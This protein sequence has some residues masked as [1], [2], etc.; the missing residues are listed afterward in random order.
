MKQLRKNIPP[1]VLTCLLLFTFLH[2]KAQ[3]HWLAVSDFGNAPTDARKGATSFR[4]NNSIYVYGGWDASGIYLTDLWKYSQSSDSWTLENATC[5]ITGGRAFAASFSIGNKAYIVGGKNLSGRHRDVWEFNSV[6]GN[7]TLLPDSLPGEI[8]EGHSAFTIGQKAYVGLGFNGATYNSD[9]YAF[10]Q[11]TLS[12]TQIPDFPGNARVYASSFTLGTKGYCGIGYSGAYENDFYCYDPVANS[13]TQIADFGGTARGAAVSF[14]ALGMGYVGMGDDGTDLKSDF[15]WYDAAA[16]AWSQTAAIEA[17]GRENGIG[18]SLSDIGYAGTGSDN[19]TNFY[20]EMW[21]W[22]NDYC[23]LELSASLSQI[24]CNADNNGAIDLTISGGAPA[25]DVL[26][27][28]GSTSEDIAN[29]SPGEYSVSITDDEGCSLNKS[30]RISEP[31]ELGFG[32]DSTVWNYAFNDGGDGID[33]SEKMCTDDAGNIYITG[34]F[35][36]DVTFGSTSMTSFGGSDIFLAK[37]NELGNLSWVISAGGTLNDV[38]NDI[39][40]DSLG[41]IYITGTFKELAFFGATQVQSSGSGAT[42]QDQE[43]FVAKYSTDGDLVWVRTAGG[44]F[45]DRGLGIYTEANGDCYVTGSFQGNATFQSHSLLSAGGDD[46]YTAKINSYGVF[47]WVNG[48]GGTSEDFGFEITKD[49]S[50]KVI[51]AGTFQNTAAFGG[52]NL[53]SLGDDDIF[54]LC[55]D[56][57]GAQQWVQQAGGPQN[58]SVSDITHDYNGFI[59]LTGSFKATASFGVN[60]LTSAGLTDI[61]IAKYSNTGSHQ[62]SYRAGGS[63]ADYGKGLNVDYRNKIYMSGAFSGTAQIDTM[64]LTS[65]GGLDI[66][67]AG[68]TAAGNFFDG[69]HVGSPTDEIANTIVQDTNDNIIISGYITGNITF[70]EHALTNLGNK[71][72]FVARADKTF[73]PRAAVVVQ[74]SC[75]E[76]GDGSIEIEVGGGTPPYTFAWSNGENTQN[77]YNLNAGSYYL[78]VTDGANCTKDTTIVLSNVNPA[79]EPPLV[80]TVD[81]TLFC[82][83]DPGDITLNAEGGSGTTLTWLKNACLESDGGQIVGTGTP[84]TIESPEDITT[85]YAR[86]ETVC[87]TSACVSI[88][89]VVLGQPT[90]PEDVAAYPDEFCELNVNFVTLS[91]DNTGHTGELLSWYENRDCIG[92]PIATGTPVDITSPSVTTWYYV[93]WETDGCGN[94]AVDSVRVIVLDGPIAVDTTY[95]DTT[96]ICLGYPNTISLSADGG[97]GD[98]LIWTIN[99]C[100]GTAVGSGTPLNIDPPTDTT[101]Y[102]VHWENYCGESECDSITINVLQTPTAPTGV[103]ADFEEFCIGE[104]DSITL[105][106]TEAYGGD[107]VWYKGYCGLDSITTGDVVKVKAPTSIT[108]YY[109]RVENLCGASPYPCPYVIITPHQPPVANFT[110]LGDALCLNADPALLNGTPTGTGGVYSTTAAAGLTDNG[111]GTASFDPALAG[112]GLWDIT[113]TYTDANGCMDDTTY[114]VAVNPLPVVNYTGLNLPGYCINHDNQPI[115]LTGNPASSSGFFYGEAI[116]DYGNGTAGFSPADGTPGG[117]YEIIYRYTDGNGCT[118]SIIKEVNIYGL[119]PALNF[120]LTEPGYCLDA[121]PIEL[122]GNQSGNPSNAGYFLGNGIQNTQPGKAF[123]VPPLAGAGVHDISYIYTNANGCTY[124]TTRTIEVYALPVAYFTGLLEN[125]CYEGNPSMLIG[126]PTDSNGV[127]SYDGPT[128]GLHDNLNGTAVFY[129]DSATAGIWNINYYYLDTVTGC[130]NDSSIAVNVYNRI[131]V[132]IDGLEDHYCVDAPDDTLVGSLAPQGTF[133]PAVDYLFDM[134]DGRVIF[135]PSIAGVGT[136]PI[137]YSWVDGNGCEGDTTILATVV[138]LPT[139]TVTSLDSNYCL[140]A[141]PDTIFGNHQPEGTFSILPG[142]GLADLGNGKAI[143]TASDAG[144]GYHYITYSFTDPNGCTKDSTFRVNVWDLPDITITGFDTSYYCYDEDTINLNGSPF[145]DLSAGFSGNGILDNDPTTG[146]ARWAA[147]LA[148]DLAGSG[149]HTISYGLSDANGCVSDTSWQIFVNA[150]PIV[151][152]SGLP[153]TL[154][155]N[156]DAITLTANPPNN[157]GTFSGNGISDLMNGTAIFDPSDPSV[158]AGT[159]V[160]ITYAFTDYNNCYNDT[161]DSVYIHPLPVKPEMII[162]DTNDYCAGIVTDLTL[163]IE[164]GWGD[165]IQW[166]MKSCG[167]SLIATTADTFL[168]ITAPT[169]TTWFWARWANQCAISECDSLQILVKLQPTIMDSIRVDTNDICAGTVDSLTLTAFGGNGDELR[170]YTDSCGGNY[171]GSGSEIRIETPADTTSFFAR[172]ESMC[173]TSDCQSLTVNIFPQPIIPDQLAVDVNNFCSGEIDSISL[174]AYGGYGTVLEWFSP[175]CGDT[176]V[177]EGDS[178]RIPAPLDTAVYFARWRNACDTT[179]CLSIQVD[180]RPLPIKPDTLMVDNNDYC[181]LSVE[182]IQLSAEGGFGD[183]VEWR[184]D[185]CNGP[186]VAQGNP[187]QP[188]PAPV[189]TTVYYASYVNNCGYSDCDSIIINVR[190][191]SIR[192]DTIMVDTNFFCPAYAGLVNLSV[193]GGLG[194]T[195]LWHRDSCNGTLLG[196]TYNNINT[197]AFQAPD[198]TTSYFVSYV[199]SCDTSDC[200]SMEVIVN[201]PLPVDTITADTTIICANSIPGNIT[202][203]AEGGRG[204]SIHWTKGSCDGEELGI[205]NPFNILPPDTTTVYFAKWVN[206]CGESECN[207]IRIIVIPDPIA[208]DTLISNHNNFCPNTL[209]SIKFT[210]VGG[211][212]DTV[213]GLPETVRWFANSCGGTEL[214]TGVEFWLVPPPIVTTQYYARWE[215][216]CGVSIC[217]TLEVLVN[218]PEPVDSVLLDTNYFCPGDVTS[219]Q[220]T[221]YGGYGDE[222]MWYKDECLTTLVVSTQNPIIVPAPDTTTTYWVTWRNQCDTAECFPVTI[223][224]NIPLTPDTIIID[225]NNYCSDYTENIQLEVLGGRG[226]TVRWFTNSC[227]GPELGLGNPLII[228]PFEDTTMVYARWENYCGVSECIELEVAVVPHPELDAGPAQDSICEEYTYTFADAWVEFADSILWTVPEGYGSFSD[229]KDINTEYIPNPDDIEEQVNVWIKLYAFGISPCGIYED[230]IRISINPTPILSISPPNPML[231]RDSSIFITAEGA[232]EYLWTPNIGLDTNRNQSVTI[233]L[234]EDQTYRMYGTSSSGC[235]DSLDFTIPVL[236]PPY[237]NLGDNLYLFTC[238]PVLLDA[239]KSDGNINYRWQDG[240]RNRTYEV[241]ED[242]EYYVS[243]W[244]EACSTSDTIFIQLCQGYMYMPN[245]FTPNKDGINEV[246]AP[247]TSDP[248]V[249]FEMR[250]Y[251]RSGRLVFTTE[252]VLEGWDGTDF[253]GTEC[254]QGIYVWQITYQGEGEIS[255]GVKRTETGRLTLLR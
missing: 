137:T 122:T 101:T 33:Q 180:V 95:A 193:E 246:F 157:L 175:T 203:Y 207:S 69:I 159:F 215:N 73:F 74:P 237:V 25:Y 72:V 47:E 113:F 116:T 170:W 88:E 185:S 13:W 6:N 129:P 77:I 92:D 145:S 244:N 178:I 133:G 40:I 124:D 173:D 205:G 78:L 142:A 248:D 3:D 96:E 192:P 61:Y 42:N 191:L 82:W 32:L 19:G 217:D 21:K 226:D 39:G 111:D 235:V 53:T 138:P 52:T 24:S 51:S 165:S 45:D 89:V 247:V 109:A 223:T 43:I 57:Y 240:S 46:I 97:Y 104:I 132:S 243:V 182:L 254:P 169:D 250:I 58:E 18:F 23:T 67:V 221:A 188:I 86:W 194:D 108:T 241:E 148:Y 27:N 206:Y 131:A 230:S 76:A 162:P 167:D 225:T 64:N 176:L 60:T 222:L 252:D 202:F 210:A 135:K 212:G 140:N 99:A 219:V 2:P 91:A 56:Q 198:T 151:S 164:G 184:I 49:V 227:E 201:E 48:A 171:I 144:P 134:S 4:I 29:L 1:L 146:T 190:P 31:M 160:H 213:S 155:V 229:P 208:P 150:L 103:L 236:P 84:L 161:I 66:L 20:R 36:S 117:P 7:W 44:Y 87:D 55:H 128:P 224:V 119:D 251:N 102:Y 63:G 83:D 234:N 118:D 30:F 10:N 15:W 232:T 115:V 166:F 231:C 65:A 238:E 158:T 28:T 11:S 26:W 187:T 114:N 130:E 168:T 245:A 141:I 8:R 17:D 93:R 186:V 127:F 199:N 22:M 209:D 81:R 79:P 85:Y 183:Y 9:F 110:G 177:A 38:S 35:T 107:V 80:A 37:Y 100:D 233:T 218:N 253:D 112:V 242:G 154:C 172:Y 174:M 105:T 197:L 70:G 156:A 106:A 249:E 98:N 163:S 195:L 12:W 59:Y 214:G 123:F 14:T 16:D 136:H 149:P 121:D 90:V 189:D 5:P 62:W 200:I 147:S 228:P 153:D 75:A 126:H 239:G 94:S 143:F 211:Y 54:I 68:Y 196:K 204:E 125:Y 50:G 181:S 139:A 179:E 41:N 34:S 216:S 71:D 255:P 220:F 120:T 152:F